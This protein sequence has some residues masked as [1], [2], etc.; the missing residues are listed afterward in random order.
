[1]KKVATYASIAK[2]AEASSST[3]RNS[4]KQQL[5]LAHCETADFGERDGVPDG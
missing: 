2:L 3:P 1:M 5:P 4:G